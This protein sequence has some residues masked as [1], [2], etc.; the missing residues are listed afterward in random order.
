MHIIFLI[1]FFILSCTPTK[2]EI[3]HSGSFYFKNNINKIIES[4]NLNAN[5]AIEIRSLNNGRT[6]YSLNRNRLLTPASNIKLIT[7]SAALEYLGDKFKFKTN[8]YRNKNNLILEGGGDPTL[9]IQSLDS[10]A[11]IISTKIKKID[12][13]FLDPFI[14]DSIKFGEG[15]MWDGGYWKHA[16]EISG[17]SINNNC[18]DFFV[19][20]GQLGEPAN[21]NFFPKTDYININN[22]SIT[23]NDTIN[24]KK[25]K[26][27]RNWI[28]N[29]NQ[30]IITGEILNS[31]L[32]DTLFR[33]IHDPSLFAGHILKEMLTDYNIPVA[34]LSKKKIDI[35]SDLISSHKS[36]YLS[37]IIKEM[38]HE[39]NN[40]YSELLI[41][42]LNTEKN[43]PRNWENGLNL[44]KSFI[45]DSVGLDTSALKIVDGSGMSRFNLVSPRQLVDILSYMWKTNN[46]KIF[47]NSL[48][49]GGKVKSTLE[50]RLQN[51]NTKIRAKTGS[52][53]GVST[54]SGYLFSEKYGPIA[55]SIL[56]NGYVGSSLPYKEL[57][58][59][60]CEWIV[61]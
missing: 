61:K 51:I 10:L 58:D 6:L 24:F 45:S 13:L 8:I 29:N 15:W 19:S 35:K 44:V 43:I 36:N 30:F 25:L 21:I 7:S 39:S 48:P 22:N 2:L 37:L 60:I 11:K 42:S 4:S 23:V 57:Q 59:N 50:E 27:E 41:K 47:L 12:T 26:I 38:M 32:T 14:I 9:S 55:F 33:N 40:L 54:L 1:I 3:D 53:Y 16:A 17:L 52:L 49:T 56:I 46:Y 20:P 31:E 5:I 18:I 28:S 34:H